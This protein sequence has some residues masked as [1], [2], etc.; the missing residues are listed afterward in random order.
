MAERNRVTTPYDDLT[1]QIIGCAMAVHRK[2]GPGYR[3]D[4][5]QRDL[6]TSLAEKEISYEAQKLYEVY[7][8][9]GNEILIGYYV[10]DFV[11]EGKVIVEIKALNRTDNSHL[12]QVIGYLAVTGCPI[13]LLIN[14]G[15]RSLGYQRVFPPKNIQVHHVN[16]QWLFIP[17]RLKDSE[18][19]P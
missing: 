9:L 14:F 15:E 16:R 19:N 6:E 13:G 5:Y 10:P 8:S 7:D 11:V 17:N 18:T 3:E 4:T 12:A 1:Y 2:L